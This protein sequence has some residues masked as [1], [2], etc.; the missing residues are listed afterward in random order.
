MAI[1]VARRAPRAHNLFMVTTALALFAAHKVFTLAVAAVFGSSISA[2]VNA[3]R[4]RR[5][6]HPSI[7]KH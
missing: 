5:P 6:L 2:V 7:R 4:A 1:V 3:P